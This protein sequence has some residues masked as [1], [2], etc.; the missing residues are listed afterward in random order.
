[1]R[2]AT[3]ISI[4]FIFC[5]SKYFFGSDQLLKTQTPAESELNMTARFAASKEYI[6]DTIFQRKVVSD[7]K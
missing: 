7:N 5:F 3:I 4:L 6:S 1:M 2:Y